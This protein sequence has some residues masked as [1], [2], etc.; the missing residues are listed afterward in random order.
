VL[1]HGPTSLDQAT[2]TDFS[3]TS[4]PAATRYHLQLSDEEDF[5]TLIANEPALVETT[6]RAA[7][8]NGATRYYWR[9]AGIDDRDRKTFS[10]T[11][12]FRTAVDRPPTV[13]LDHPPDGA[14]A[15][16]K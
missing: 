4:A 13:A 11:R 14:S 1:R 2:T 9:V 3:W 15:V 5:S 10:Q 6:Y 12:R 7:E 16:T 8:L